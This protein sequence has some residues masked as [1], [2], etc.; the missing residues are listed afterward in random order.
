MRIQV[1]SDKHVPI[2]EGTIELLESAVA[3]ALTRFEQRLT[4]VE[5]H[6]HAESAGRGAGHVVSCLMEARPAGQVPVVV[7]HR[8]ASVTEAVD[9]TS[10]KLATLL[11]TR[12]DRRADRRGRATIRH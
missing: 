5:V 9:G 2:G 7:T 10:D 11:S 8:A 12:F 1:N 3:S 4:R 6:L